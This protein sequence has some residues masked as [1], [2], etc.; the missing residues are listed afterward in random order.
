MIKLDTSSK[1]SVDSLVKRLQ[2][3]HKIGGIEAFTMLHYVEEKIWERENGRSD[4]YSV[5]RC[6]VQAYNIINRYYSIKEKRRKANY[7]D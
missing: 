3:N 1:F 2:Y 4:E 7:Y 5:P 6:Y